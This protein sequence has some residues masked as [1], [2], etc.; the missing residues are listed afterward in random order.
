MN[1][2]VQTFGIF[3]K[4]TPAAIFGLCAILPPAAFESLKTY[5]A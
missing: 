2:S 4:Y 1:I 3:A 5:P